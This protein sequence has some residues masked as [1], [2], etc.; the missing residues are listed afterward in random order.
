MT[1]LA[2]SPLMTTE[3]LLA[4]P[5][6]GI[7]RELIGGRLLEKPMTRRNRR[8]SRTESN[9]TRLLGQWLTTRPEPRGEVLSGE[10]GFRIRRDPETTL[11][12]DVPSITPETPRPPPDRAFL[13]SI[14][15]RPA[16]HI[17]P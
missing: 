12:S 13:L 17:P 3:Q 2:Q 11:G 14:V 6:D 7:D 10:A 1:T 8:H 16:V 9:V 15:P 4:F 5:E